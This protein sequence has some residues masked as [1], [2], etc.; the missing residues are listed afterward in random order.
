MSKLQDGGL[1]M[2]VV[3]LPVPSGQ[4]PR[5]ALILAMCRYESGNLIYAEEAA[6]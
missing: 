5:V 6:P 1:P 4:P 3:N 2:S